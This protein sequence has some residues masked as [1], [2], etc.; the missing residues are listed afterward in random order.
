MI[1]VPQGIVIVEDE[2][3]TQPTG[4]ESPEFYYVLEDDSELS[5][6]D[7]KNPEQNTDPNT[8]E[9]IVTMDF[10][11]DGR[12]RF[13]NVTKRIAERGSEQIKPTGA[14]PAETFQ[15]FAITLDNQIVSLATIDY[16]ENPEGIDGRTGAQINGI[17]SLE[18]TQDLAESLRIGALP[19]NLKLISKTQ[20]SATLG[21][22]ALNEGL[23]AG[24]RRPRADA[25]LPAPLLPGAR[26]AGVYRAARL[27]GAA[28]RPGQ[29][30][31][32]HADAAGHR[33]TD[34][35]ARRRGRREHR[36]LRT[37]KGRGARRA[38]DP[39]R[40][41]PPATRR[42]CARSSTRTS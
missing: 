19:I 17:G 30:D 31:P 32:D 4:P 1:K 16:L 25:A 29:A 21:K 7:I 13:A 2:E 8:Q 33:G 18:D 42:R 38:V 14:D 5:G 6:S 10:T 20:V 22:Q 24:A 23:L 39:G 36:R 35:H 12:R 40:R 37:N 15:R 34:P 26:R 3:S 27:R 28:V 41:S 11:D 9:P